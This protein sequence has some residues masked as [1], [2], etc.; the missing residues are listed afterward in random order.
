MQTVRKRRRTIG[1]GMMIVGILFTTA[2]C[3]FMSIQAVM[4]YKGS[5]YREYD[6]HM[7]DVLLYLE[8]TM[9]LEDF[10]QCMETG[11]P[12]EKYNE[13]QQRIND[14]V[15]DFELLYL[16]VGIPT[17]TDT[18]K[19]IM[20]NGISSTSDAERAAGDTED[21]A[22]GYYD[23]DF[24]TEEQLAP[25][26]EAWNKPGRF[27]GFSNKEGYFESTY[28][29]CKPLLTPEGEVFA[30]LCADISLDEMHRTVNTYI[31]G[32]VALILL[33][34][35]AFSVSTGTWLSRSVSKPLASLEKSARGFADKSRNAKDISQLSYDPPDIHTEN[36]IE[37]LS[38][39][40][41]KMAGD[42]KEYVED[43]L[44]AEQRAEA[45]QEEVKDISRVAY[46]D[47]LTEVGS[48]TAY[49]TKKKELLNKIAEGNAEFALVLVDLNN[50]KR[51][52]DTYGLENGDKYIISAAQLI[53]DVYRDTTVYRAEGD[54]FVVILEGEAFDKREELLDVLDERFAAAQTDMSRPLWERCSAAA[55]M[56]D[57]SAETDNDV[58]QV[59]RR[60]EKIMLRNKRMMK[61]DLG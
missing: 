37:L 29:V 21:I 56:T 16:Y 35:I 31:F 9:D 1:R 26:F 18:G 49:D 10:R 52:N 8:G 57:F 53:A 17:R 33:I 48:K 5:L 39:A 61:N 47:S 32:S 50:L 25:Y 7:K 58:D 11:V 51:I 54:E 40:I 45:A 46:K 6:A 2:V 22:I 27:S 24:Y 12:S 30:L 13:L 43:I 60:A 42:M 20:I 44:R 14:M 55:G 36:E 28:I 4:V 38:D 34:C 23:E 59:Y 19:G 15:D 41:T 3:L